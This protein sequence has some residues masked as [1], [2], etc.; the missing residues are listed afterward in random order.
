M[1]TRQQFTSQDIMELTLSQSH[2]ETCR[3]YIQT[4]GCQMNEYDSHCVLRS[5]ISRGYCITSHITQADVI[6]L[7]TCCV[8]EKAEQKAFSFLGRLRRLKERR[9]SLRIIVAGCLAQQLGTGLLARFDHVDLVVGTRGI[10]SVSQLAEE[11]RRTTRR[12]AYLPE[13]DPE[14]HYD[15]FPETIFNS[16]VASPVTIMQGCDNFCTYCIV[17]FVRGR[18]RSRP[19]EMILQEI[20]KL[21]DGGAREVL[22]LG[23]NVNSYGSGLKEVIGFP[24]LLRQIHTIPNLLRIRFTTSHPKDLNEDLIRC[25]ADLPKLCKH[26]HLPFQAGSDRV[27]KRM[28]RGYTSSEY[29]EKIQKLREVCPDIGLSSDVMVGFPGETEEDFQ[30]TVRL[31][32]S[33]QFDT[34]FSFR[35]SDRPGTKS[36]QFPDKVDE[37]IK[38]RRLKELQGVQDAITRRKYLAEQGKVKEVLV[39]GPSKASNGQMTGRTHQ[40]RIVNF[41]GPSKLIGKAV[42][43]RIVTAFSHSLRGDLLPAYLKGSAPSTENSKEASC[44][45]K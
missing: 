38:A 2:T 17:P 34:L 13:D 9:P 27:L 12:M 40:N 29:H 1:K 8:R 31:L 28:N 37:S 43:V 18:E 36:S 15:T 35:Y 11:V 24:E 33:V 16:P 44:S 14:C 41:D 19:S 45:G 39:E 32:E 21:V 10:P 26:L 20:R 3:L 7:N 23:Q 4:F 42:D 22:L 30:E 6:F 25:F 5:L